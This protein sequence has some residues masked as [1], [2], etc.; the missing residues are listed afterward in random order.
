MADLAELAGLAGL[1]GLADL[2]GHHETY[3][4]IVSIAKISDSVIE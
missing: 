1:A 3:P 2:A 4:W